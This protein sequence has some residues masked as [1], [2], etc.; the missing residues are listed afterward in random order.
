MQLSI[1]RFTTK[2]QEVQCGVQADHFSSSPIV[3]LHHRARNSEI[4]ELRNCPKQAQ[5]EKG[6]EFS[7]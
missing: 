1:C 7:G 2:N 5:G 6:E 3:P 4:L